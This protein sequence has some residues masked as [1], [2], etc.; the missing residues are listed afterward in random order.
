MVCDGFTTVGMECVE[1][2]VRM[3]G[4]EKEGEGRVELCVDGFWGTVC[5]DGFDQKAAFVICRHFGFHK[6]ARMWVTQSV[7]NKFIQL[8]LVM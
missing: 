5:G 6:T 8:L 7:Y 2:E 4:G 3:I 1:G